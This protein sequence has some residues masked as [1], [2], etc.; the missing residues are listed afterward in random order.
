MDCIHVAAD[1]KQNSKKETRKYKKTSKAVARTADHTASQHLWGLCDVIG[2]V[3][4]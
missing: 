2:H 3:T 4:I 1:K